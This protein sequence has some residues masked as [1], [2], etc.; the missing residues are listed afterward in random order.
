MNDKRC[1]FSRFAF[2][3]NRSVM[4]I[5]YSPYNRQSKPGSVFPFGSVKRLE[6]SGQILFWNSLPGIGNSYFYVV[7][8]PCLIHCLP[9]LPGTFRIWAALEHSMRRYFKTV[10]R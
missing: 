3:V 4:V 7:F 2:G 9:L 5:Y 10:N 6:Q 1:T 8:L